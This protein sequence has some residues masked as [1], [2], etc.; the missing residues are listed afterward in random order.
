M[1]TG[2]VRELARLAEE[3]RAAE[4]AVKR[5]EKEEQLLIASN[6]KQDNER[7]RA[8]ETRRVRLA[9]LK[10]RREGE[11]LRGQLEAARNDALRRRHEAEVHRKNHSR[12]SL[13][14]TFASRIREAK[15]A[16]ESWDRMANE[17]KAEEAADRQKRHFETAKE[18][19]Q[20]HSHRME[21]V[22]SMQQSRIATR[23]DTV[24]RSKEFTDMAAE[25]RAQDAQ[26]LKRSAQIR[27]LESRQ[28]ISEARDQLERRHH[29]EK[30][31]VVDHLIHTRSKEMEALRLRASQ[32]SNSVQS[33]RAA[34][35]NQ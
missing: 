33:L 15:E 3:Q 23:A 16:Q 34:S 2:R 19:S 35:R 28:R 26:Q 14:Q 30:E 18:R 1:S 24:S 25:R 7:R 17:I 9:V 21:L 32:L 27:R 4:L 22:S 10:D 31:A 8:D 13:V 11:A 6:N 12:S 20:G 5:L 29:A